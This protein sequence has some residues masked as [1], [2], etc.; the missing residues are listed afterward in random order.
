MSVLKRI[1]Y[2]FTRVAEGL[3]YFGPPPYG[4]IPFVPPPN[5]MGPRDAETAPPLYFPNQQD[6]ASHF[7]DPSSHDPSLHGHPHRMEAESPNVT[8]PIIYENSEGFPQVDQSPQAWQPQ[9]STQA[10]IETVTTATTAVVTLSN[11]PPRPQYPPHHCYGLP[12][13]LDLASSIQLS[14]RQMLA[15]LGKDAAPMPYRPPSTSLPLMMVPYPPAANSI[16]PTRPPP[17]EFSL[18]MPPPNPEVV[19]WLNTSQ[20]AHGGLDVNGNA[21]ARPTDVSQACHPAPSAPTSVITEFPATGAESLA[22][23]F[24]L[25]PNIAA[26]GFQDDGPKY[27]QVMLYAHYTKLE[28]L[29]RLLQCYQTPTTTTVTSSKPTKAS[30]VSSTASLRY[31]YNLATQKQSAL[32]SETIFHRG[33]SGK[34]R[35]NAMN[36]TNLPTHMPV[37]PLLIPEEDPCVYGATAPVEG[38]AGGRILAVAEASSD[39]VC[40]LPEIQRSSRDASVHRG[41]ADDSQVVHCHSKSIH[42]SRL[43]KSVS[44]GVSLKPSLSPILQSPSTPISGGGGDSRRSSAR[45]SLSLPDVESESQDGHSQDDGGLSQSA[46]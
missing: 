16:Y 4:C 42:Q 28:E 37:Q 34:Q 46:A 18:R 10:P 11:E 27:F 12:P 30:H 43:G 25:P 8:L 13:P 20:H 44:H 31:R 6:L 39:H 38:A 2:L 45:F 26:D 29:L 17:N 15:S 32:A 33:K 24:D 35:R 23:S 14:A 40:S 36:Q 9:I 19:K 3:H 5:L 41:G 21:F 1:P 7:Q 22:S